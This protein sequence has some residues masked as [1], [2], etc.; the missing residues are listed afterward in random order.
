MNNMLNNKLNE[1]EEKVINDYYSALKEKDKLELE[2]S[3]ITKEKT[4][5]K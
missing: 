1:E 5:F 3:N 2:I 4:N